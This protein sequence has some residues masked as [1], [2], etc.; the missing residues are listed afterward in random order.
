M[1]SVTCARPAPVQPGWPPLTPFTA[2][3]LENPLA[4]AHGLA[5]PHTPTPNNSPGPGRQAG[6]TFMPVLSP[7]V[8]APRWWRRLLP[9]QPCSFLPFYLKA[10]GA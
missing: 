10:P 3:D 5:N 4:P 2:D 8:G 6:T 9:G 7:R 1:R